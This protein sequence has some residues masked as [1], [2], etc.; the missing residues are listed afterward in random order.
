MPYQ[1]KSPEINY[2]KEANLEEVY[3]E[4]CLKKLYSISFPPFSTL[5]KILNA[6]KAAENNFSK[7]FH[8]NKKE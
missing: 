7:L 8:I 5:D 3:N 4:E 2:P 6:Q 1:L